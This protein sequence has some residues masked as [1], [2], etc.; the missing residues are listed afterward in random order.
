MRLVFCDADRILCDGL[1]VA[2]ATRGH[3]A[4]AI[5]TTVTEGIAAVAAD[6]PDACLLSARF[7]RGDDG[8]HAARTIRR[9]YPGTAVL[10]LSARADPAASAAARRAGAAGFLAKDQGIGSLAD[11]LDVI[12]E[13]R[14][15][16]AAARAGDA[17]PAE[18]VPS[19]RAG[20]GRTADRPGR[21]R[22]SPRRIR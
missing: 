20:T 19:G 10:L 13:G 9:R 8:L 12:A 4:V 21:R 17:L 2:L 15:G 3:Q 18:R 5:T 11:A 14:A 22:T 7:P 16:R 6:Q 1:A